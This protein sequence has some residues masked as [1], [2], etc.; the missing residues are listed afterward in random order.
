[1]IVTLGTKE[2]RNV[3]KILQ[4]TLFFTRFEFYDKKRVYGN[5]LLPDIMSETGFNYLA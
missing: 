4:D 2:V 1:M 3:Y 5:R